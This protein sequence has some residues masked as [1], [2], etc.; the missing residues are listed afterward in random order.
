MVTY[1]V[2]TASRHTFHSSW[3]Q[4]EAD[5]L[6]SRQSVLSSLCHLRRQT[7]LMH[8]Q[9]PLQNLYSNLL[10][11]LKLIIKIITSSASY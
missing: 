1:L 6:K 11:L 2:G 7:P 5:S 4:Q 10:I 9:E 3:H 8:Y